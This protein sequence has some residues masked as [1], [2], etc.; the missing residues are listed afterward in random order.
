[1]NNQIN[2]YFEIDYTND[3]LRKLLG[4]V[5]DIQSDVLKEY[6]KASVYRMEVSSYEN[7]NELN[8][9]IDFLHRKFEFLG[10]VYIYIKRFIESRN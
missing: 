3:D 10:S 8:N 2:K 4:I 5:L 1:M 6:S 9:Y 7:Y